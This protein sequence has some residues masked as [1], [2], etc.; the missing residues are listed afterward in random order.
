MKIAQELKQLAKQMAYWT[1]P[2]GIQEWVRSTYKPNLRHIL[3]PAASKA[4][5]KQNRQFHNC[6]VGE[7]CFILATGPSIKKQDLKPLQN[8]VCIAVSN[9]FVH[10][11]YALIKPRYYCIAPYHLPITEE[12]FQA[13]MTD[14]A[15]G[16]GNATMFFSLSD[17]DRIQQNGNFA[18][19]QHH[20]LNFAGTWSSVS[21]AGVDLFKPLP[22]PQ[23]VPIMALLIAL[24]MGFE[25]IYLVGCDHDWILHFNESTHFYDETQHAL[26]KNGYS[27]WNSDLEAECNAYIKLW[28]SYKFL[29][30]IAHQQSKQI[31]NATDGG[32]LDVFCRVKYE[33]LF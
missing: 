26:N 31:L 17:L 10:P 1:V 14:L 12:A 7:R 11:D 21:H 8:E 4:V 24:Y 23:S 16:S 9:F 22:V 28:K 6:H 15:Q 3:L 5:L 2:S 20:Y 33:S 18:S 30:A 32:L 13:W 19:R 29:R 27:E 25:T